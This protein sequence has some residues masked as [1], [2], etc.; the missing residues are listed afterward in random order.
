VKKLKFEIKNYRELKHLSYWTNHL[1]VWNKSTYFIAS[2]N[3]NNCKFQLR[4]QFLSLS[5]QR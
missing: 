1:L 3:F 2:T 5:A 4:Y